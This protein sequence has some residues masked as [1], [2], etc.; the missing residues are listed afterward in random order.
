MIEL[1]TILHYD[2]ISSPVKEVVSIRA[3]MKLGKLSYFQTELRKILL[4]IFQVFYSHR[5]N[6]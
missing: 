1:R 6:S 2:V 3:S 5:H 4:D